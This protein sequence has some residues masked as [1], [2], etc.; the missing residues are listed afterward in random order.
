[1]RSQISASVQS[2][3]REFENH[4]TRNQAVTTLKAYRRHIRGYFTEY[5]TLS[6][7]DARTYVY[8]KASRSEERMCSRALKAYDRWLASEYDEPQVLTKLRLVKEPAPVKTP[9]VEAADVKEMLQACL[10]TRDHNRFLAFRDHALI[11]VMASTGCR[12]GEVV[13]MTSEHIDWTSGLITLPKTKNG[14][15]RVVRLTEDA[16]RSVKRYWRL[17]EAHTGPLWR[18]GPLSRGLTGEAL[19]RV[20]ERRANEAGCPHVTCH[21]FRRGFAVTWLAAGGSETYLRTMTGWKSPAMAQRYVKVVE[22]REALE[23]HRR[24]FG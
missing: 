17:V 3:L 8:G 16:L 11:S 18:T 19:R 1:M 4:W 22:Q 12:R 15:V 6:L 5:A 21:A 10:A 7:E 14:D 2:D 9:M 13:G 24:M 23:T 20:V